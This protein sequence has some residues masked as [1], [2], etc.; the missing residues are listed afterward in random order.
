MIRNLRETTRQNV[1]QDWLKTNLERFTRMLQGQR[2]LD[3]VSNMILSELAPLVSAQHGVFYS[4][5]TRPTAASPCSQLQAGYGY[6]ERRQL[7]KSF[8][9]GEGLVGPVRARRRS[10]SCSP[11]FP[12]TTCGSTRASARSAP[13]NI[14]VMPVL[15]EGSLSR[16]HR[17]RLVLA[18]QRSPTRR[19]S[20]SSPRASAS[21]STRSKPTRSPRTLL[22]QSQS[23]AEELRSQQEELR[24]SNA[25]LERQASLLAEQNIEAERKNQEVEQSK[26]L[27]EEKAGELAISSKYKSEF[28]AN[29]S[30]EL[31]TPLNSLLI[32]AQQLEDNPDHNMTDT[33]V[34]YAS[35][36][37]RVRQRPARAAQQH[38]GS[39]QGGVGNWTPR[40]P[41]SPSATLRTAMFASSSSS[42]RATVS[43]YS[44]DVAPDS[45]ETIV[46]DPQRLRQILKNLLANAFKFTEHGMCTCRSASTDT[47]WSPDIGAARQRAVGDR[48]RRHATPASASTPISSN[49]SSKRS[50]RATARPRAS[51]A[52]RASAFRSAASSST[53]SAARSPS[54]ARPARAA[55]SPCT[56]RLGRPSRYPAPVRF[57]RLRRVAR[58][59]LD[60]PVHGRR[61][62]RRRSGVLAQRRRHAMV[63]RRRDLDGPKILVVD[64]DYRNIFALSAAP[65]T[66]PRRRAQSPRAVPKRS[67]T[68]ERVPDFDIVLMDIMMP[69]MDGYDTIRAIRAHRRVQEPPDHRGDRQGHCR[70]SVNA[71]S[72]P[73]PTTTSEARRHRG[74]PRCAP[75]V[76]PDVRPA[77]S[78]HARS[79]PRRCSRRSRRHRRSDAVTGDE[80]LA[81]VEWR[82]E[83]P[84]DRTP[85]RARRDRRHA[86]PVVDDD[87]RNIFAMS[88]LL[89]RGHADVLVAESGAERLAALERDSRHRR[90]AHGHHD[91]G[92]GRLRDHP[93]DPRRRPVQ[94]PSH[95]RGDRQGDPGRAPTLPRRR[96]RRLRA[97]A[98]DIRASC[99]A[100]LTPWLP[101]AVQSTGGMSITLPVRRAAQR[102]HTWRARH[103]CRC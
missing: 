26:R 27:L 12:P 39:G 28:I 61:L 75:A 40:W 53:C 72:T 99:F 87:F 10:A 66:R 36:I 5:T 2:N 54:P 71:A 21:S 57:R 1:E 47:G 52:V 76:A 80:S 62:D 13:L 7:S 38:P 91:A 55:R 100:A 59:Q 77:R 60:P 42:P 95:H 70:A 23:L 34:E 83:Q 19:S 14:I 29:M 82:A 79:S 3:T 11:K 43:R 35:V 25:D 16:R 69:V 96:R 94:E 33:Q 46:T 48:L 8:R 92:D 65:R 58:S 103:R 101:A 50:P 98:R 45:P 6:E 88:A 93:R 51:T 24:E 63:R 18:L 41:S 97:E 84:T 90:R 44:I 74:A 67:P 4:M 86:N 64:D 31:R 22:M 9:M 32:L 17:A 78:R 73:A 89:E 68:L 81:G 20:T 15:F 30:H 37:Q 85:A 56:C 49:G 102:R